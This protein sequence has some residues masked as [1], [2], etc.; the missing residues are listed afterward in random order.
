MTYINLFIFW[1]FELPAAY[2]LAYSFGLGPIGVFIAMTVSFSMLA[3][4]SAVIFKRGSW[5]E[6][7]V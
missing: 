5:K 7:V 4:V 1:L 3:V 6:K 2:W